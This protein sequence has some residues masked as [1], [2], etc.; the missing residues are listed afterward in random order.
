MHD[1]SLLA[2]VFGLIILLKVLV[3]YTSYVPASRMSYDLKMSLLP[4]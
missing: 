2:V 4:V 1:E 3:I